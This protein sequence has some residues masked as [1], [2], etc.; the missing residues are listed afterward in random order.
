MKRIISSIMIAVALLS[1]TNCSNESDVNLE[2][3]NNLLSDKFATYLLNYTPNDF[4][5]RTTELY[6]RLDHSSNYENSIFYM[7]TRDENFDQGDTTIYSSVC[8]YSNHNQFDKD[9]IETI[10]DD[11]QTL[12]S[13]AFF[14]KMDY[15]TT[16]VHSEVTN[17]S[18]KVYLTSSI[19]EFK[20]IKYSVHESAA[21]VHNPSNDFDPCFD[22]CMENNIRQE[23]DGANWIDWGI[24]LASAAETTAG[25]VGSC[26]WN[27]I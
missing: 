19:E 10:L 1:F 4:Q 3:N 13:S 5:A 12:D 11:F 22:A 23:L 6:N 25:W 14:S 8:G 27:C 21:K 9:L 24:F 17:S 2:E 26:I 16:F 15:L 18:Q 20:W 7:I